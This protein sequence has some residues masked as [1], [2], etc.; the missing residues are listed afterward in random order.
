MAAERSDH[1]QIISLL[2]ASASQGGIRKELESAGNKTIIPLI[3]RMDK[4]I[5]RIY[6]GPASWAAAGAFESLGSSEHELAAELVLPPGVPSALS[7]A[8]FRFH[9]SYAS[10]RVPPVKLKPCSRTANLGPCHI[11]LV[12]S[13]VQ[14]ELPLIV[15]SIL[16]RIALMHEC[17]PL[18]S[19]GLLVA[20]RLTQLR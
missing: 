7:K 20:Y 18:Y 5:Q 2:V 17:K 1:R 16:P 6:A 10:D 4:G 8:A 3:I 9:V 12:S 13:H 11:N 14:E 15:V 19:G